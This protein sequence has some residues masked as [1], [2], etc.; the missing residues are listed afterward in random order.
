MAALS[1]CHQELVDWD[2]NLVAASAA[3]V[4]VATVAVAAVAAAAA[5][6]II[7]PFTVFRRTLRPSAVLP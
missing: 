1:T 7:I 5:T 4:V 6:N 2:G 3:A